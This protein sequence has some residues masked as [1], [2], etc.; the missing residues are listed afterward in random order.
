MVVG[1]VVY[2]VGTC[3]RCLLLCLFLVIWRVVVSRQSTAGHWWVEGGDDRSWVVEREEGWPLRFAKRM[4]G[5]CSLVMLVLLQTSLSFTEIDGV[6]EST[7]FTAM[8]HVNVLLLHL[9]L[10]PRGRVI[11]HTCTRQGQAQETSRLLDVRGKI[12][13]H[14]AVDAVQ[15]PVAV[16]VER[17]ES[18]HHSYCIRL[19]PTQ[20]RSSSH[21][22]SIVHALRSWNGS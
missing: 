2:S 22:S 19:L 1:M 21:L 14:L 20:T 11:S 18:L 6:S 13:D 16:P 3:R 17:I 15:R 7:C 4:A 5:R 9:L 12:M 10:S 8:Q